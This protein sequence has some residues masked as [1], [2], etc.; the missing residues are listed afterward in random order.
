MQPSTPTII[1][2]PV[3]LERLQAAQGAVDL[4]LGVLANAARV[5]QDRVGLARTVDHFVA[6]AGPGS[7]A[8]NSLSRTFIWQPTVSM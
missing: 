7:A 2:R 4:V 3:L 6:G 1:S 8:T 5:E